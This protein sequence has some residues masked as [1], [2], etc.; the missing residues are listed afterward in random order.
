MRDEAGKLSLLVG[1]CL[2]V[3]ACA[4]SVWADVIWVGTGAGAGFRQEVDVQGIEDDQLVFLINGNRGTTALGRVRQIELSGEP[5]FNQAEVAFAAGDW[6]RAAAEYLPVARLHAK[7][8]VRRRSAERLIDAAQRAGRFDQAVT[9]YVHL[10]QVA[11]AAAIGREPVLPEQ[12]EARQLELSANEL[13]RAVQEGVSPAQARPLLALLLNVHNRRGDEKA[14]GEVVERLSR[15]MGGDPAGHDPA[16]FAQVLIGRANLALSRGESEQAIQLINSQRE[17]FQEPRQQSDALMILAKAAELQARDDRARLM[18]AAVAYMR[19]VS[20]FKR[21]EG[22][23]NVP[24]ALLK[25]AQLHEK[26]GLAEPAADIYRDLVATYPDS[27]AAA[28]AQKR[29]ESTSK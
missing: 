19:V 16:L 2:V 9:G 6:E 11:P 21:A 18:D 17:L 15:V 25:V 14:A 24:E 8:W 22:A 7:E 1:A 10:S 3:L 20:H 13:D 27:S 23:P 26:L 4:G 5:G 12:V 28:E 29:L